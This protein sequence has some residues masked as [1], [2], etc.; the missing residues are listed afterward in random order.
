MITRTHPHAHL[1]PPLLDIPLQPPRTDD[2]GSA[3]RD[4]P[5]VLRQECGAQGRAY[6]VRPRAQDEHDT[7]AREEVEVPACEGGVLTRGVEVVDL[8]EGLVG[9]A[10]EAADDGDVE[11]GLG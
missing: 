2:G 1:R 4:D 10:A 3:Y 7:L 9:A 11:G 8:R 5:H 6:Q